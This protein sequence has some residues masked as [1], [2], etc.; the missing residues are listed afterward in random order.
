MTLM[1]KLRDLL[2][3]PSRAPDNAGP[4][5]ADTPAR[6]DRTQ[7]QGRPTGEPSR[8]D[9]GRHARTAEPGDRPAE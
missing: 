4:A 1:D 6:S 7:P 8:T 9:G 2:N 5:L 3:R